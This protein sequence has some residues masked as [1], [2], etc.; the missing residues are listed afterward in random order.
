MEAKDFAMAH[1]NV[2][3]RYTRHGLVAFNAN[4]YFMGR[5]LESYGEYS[6]G[7]SELFAKVVPAGATALDIGANI[8]LHTLSL[9]RAVGPRGAVIAIEPQRSMFQLLCANLALNGLDNVRAMEV[10]MGRK[11]A[12]AFIP[13]VDYNKVGNYGG[14]ALREEGDPVEV[15]TLDSLKLAECHFIKIDVEG[16]EEGVIAG[17]AKTIARLQPVLYVE[18]DREKSSSTLIA[19]IKKLGYRLFWH[20][21]PLFAPNNYYGNAENIFPTVVSINMLCLPAKDRRPVEG[22]REVTGHDD[23]PLERPSASGA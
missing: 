22:L 4:D 12:T 13:R 18:N 17:A 10:A 11:A 9:A 3:I 1:G 5:S 7:E 16:Q 20:L 19:A 8:G 15:I 21:P 14:I 6:P 23:W 2:R